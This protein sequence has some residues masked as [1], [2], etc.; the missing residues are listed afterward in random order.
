MQQK[1]ENFD[2]QL[3][4]TKTDL[5]ESVIVNGE[6]RISIS[7]M[8]PQEL[9]LSSTGDSSTSLLHQLIPVHLRLGVVS[10]LL[11]QLQYRRGVISTTN[12]THIK[13]QQLE[14]RIIIIKK[15]KKRKRKDLWRRVAMSPSLMNSFLFLLLSTI[16]E[17][18]S[19]HMSR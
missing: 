4:I 3:S 6:E 7:K 11:K 13:S 18:N 5:K 19:N 1:S 17:G 9:V 8:A 2:T 15:K 14:K 16:F 10:H 12:K